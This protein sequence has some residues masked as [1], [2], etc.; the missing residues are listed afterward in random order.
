MSDHYHYGYADEYHSHPGLESLV[1]GLREDLRVAE[2]RIARLEDDL[3]DALNR[4]HVLEDQ[5]P[6][7]QL[8]AD[9]AAAGLTESEAWGGR[10]PSASYAE[11]AREG[12]E[13]EAYLDAAEEARDRADD[14]DD[15]S[16]WLP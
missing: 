12:T 5:T 2:S 1:G 9:Q 13:S 10:G 6:Q 16:G 11:W 15:Y 3:R 7:L 4:L 8:E 14:G